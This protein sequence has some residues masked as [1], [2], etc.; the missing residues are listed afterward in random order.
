MYID[1]IIWCNIFYFLLGC[2]FMSILELCI[3]CFAIR[4]ID[5][6]TV[7]SNELTLNQ[8]TVTNPAF[9]ENIE[10]FEEIEL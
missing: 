2:L 5:A 4:T 10:N 3:I 7:Q 1:K 9:Q 8:I 6:E